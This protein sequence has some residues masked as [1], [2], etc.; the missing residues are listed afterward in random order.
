MRWGTSLTG[1]LPTR[2]TQ[3]IGDAS[4]IGI[5][6][7]AVGLGAEVAAQFRPAGQTFALVLAA[8][9]WGIAGLGMGLSYPRLLAQPFDNLP[10]SRVVPVGTAIAFAEA[11]GTAIGSLLGGGVYSLASNSRH[12]ASTSIGWAYILLTVTAVATGAISARRS[13]PAPHQAAEAPR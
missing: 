12:A 4:T 6:F 13:H 8:V 10:P 3:R 2:F 11:A 7:L 9:G 5:A 1:L